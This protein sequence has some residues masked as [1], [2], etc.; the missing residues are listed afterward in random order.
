MGSSEGGLSEE[1]RVFDII[2]KMSEFKDSA[3]RVGE[4]QRF[5]IDR[6]I[7]SYSEFLDKDKNGE[8]LISIALDKLRNEG[9]ISILDAGCGTGRALFGLKD[10]LLF[11]TQQKENPNVVEAVGVNDKNFSKESEMWLVHK[12]NA[13]GFIRY[14]I[15]RLETVKL[16]PNYF[17]LIISYE[18]LIHNSD[19]NVVNIME[20]MVKSLAPGGR[21]YFDLL[22]EQHSNPQI[23]EFLKKAKQEKYK[24]YENSMEKKPLWQEEEERIFVVL[25]KHP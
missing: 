8:N 24:V 7:F 11:R 4:Y 18:T 17:D 12:A 19:D 6:G 1:F 14:I 16:P 3:D 10:Q 2:V 13:E 5:N 21:F 23:S 22:A 20:N 15:D 9:K 25:E